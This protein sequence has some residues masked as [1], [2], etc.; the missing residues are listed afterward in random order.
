MSLQNVLG[1]LIPPLLVF[2]A[3]G[4][5][6]TS[7]PSRPRRGG[8]RGWLLGCIPCIAKTYGWDG[9]HGSQA[10]GRGHTEVADGMHPWIAKTYGLELLIHILNSSTS[11]GLVRFSALFRI[12]PMGYVC[13]RGEGGWGRGGGQPN[14]LS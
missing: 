7:G 12:Q 6:R 4:L 1:G 14:K 5:G 13:V 9:V 10:E 11:N 2:L 3:Q 8:T